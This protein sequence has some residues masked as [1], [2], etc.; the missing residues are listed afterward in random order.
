MPSKIVSVEKDFK[1]V[2]QSYHST[3]RQCQKPCKTGNDTQAQA[4]KINYLCIQ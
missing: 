3:Y 2:A 4:L 1:L